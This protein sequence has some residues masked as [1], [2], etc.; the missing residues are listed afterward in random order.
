M[1]KTEITRGQFAA[2]VVD[3][4]YDAGDKC[5]TFDGGTAQDRNYREQAGRNWRN[6][7]Y[8]QDDNHPVVCV[9]WQ[10]A[11]A[12]VEWLSRKTG[13]RYRLPSEAE[14]EYSARAGTTT[15]RPWGENADDACA[16]AN[17]W[18]M[19]AK[20]EIS[21]VKQE[22]HICTDKYAFTA[23][24]ASFKPN[25]F[26][27]YDMIGNAWEWVEDCWHNDYNGAPNDGSAW[28]ERTCQLRLP[29]GGSW[30]DFSGIV[31][32]AARG[33]KFG[34]PRNDS[35][36]FRV[37][38]SLPSSVSIAQITPR[39]RADQK[40]VEYSF[41]E[42]ADLGA[43]LETGTVSFEKQSNGNYVMKLMIPTR[44]GVLQKVK[45]ED[46]FVLAVTAV[47]VVCALRRLGGELEKTAAF[48]RDA[49]SSD[50]VALVDE[51]EGVNV[52]PDSAQWGSGL[53]YYIPFNRFAF[54]CR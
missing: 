34:L 42:L 25:A 46:T 6:P 44:G 39:S 13:K 53:A 10:D 17:V 3:A 51:G 50:I 52:T 19:T 2:F 5:W 43:G 23:P 37:A 30:K 7:G 9:S 21:G 49:G 11:K 31:Y 8:A 28:T 14:W 36:G 40:R 35:I 12:Y 22:S 18:D 4:N 48:V 32:S 20:A 54:R 47:P 41:K 16:Y 15:S 33:A 45:L 26:G 24:V 27:L 38:L 29:R 1:S